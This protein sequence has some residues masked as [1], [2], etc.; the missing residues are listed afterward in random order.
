MR[1]ATERLSPHLWVLSL[2]TPH[3]I[4]NALTLQGPMVDTMMNFV[5]KTQPSPA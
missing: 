5:A 2:D 1:R 4:S 3:R